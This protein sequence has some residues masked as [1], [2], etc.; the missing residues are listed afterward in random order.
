[1]VF[2]CIF[3][4]ERALPLFAPFNAFWRLYAPDRSFTNASR[5]G[6]ER[7]LKVL[8]GAP[9]SPIRRTI[10]RWH[11]AGYIILHPLHA[12]PFN[13]FRKKLLFILRLILLLTH[14]LRIRF[15]RITFADQLLIICCVGVLMLVCE[16]VPHCSSL[17]DTSTVSADC[18]AV[19]WRLYTTFLLAP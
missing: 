5:S 18:L 16:V 7:R 14:F 15:F 17:S 2:C 11:S 10:T 1:M 13:V 12:P 4:G 19:V 6:V 3:L 9:F 8:G